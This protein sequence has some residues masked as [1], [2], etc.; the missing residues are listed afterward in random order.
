MN[1]QRLQTLLISL[2]WSFPLGAW[3]GGAA[4]AQRSEQRTA[5]PS[6]QRELPLRAIV[7]LQGLNVPPPQTQGSA[8]LSL[9]PL[10]GTRV[11]TVPVSLG[12]YRGRFLLDTGASTSMV[13]AATVQQLQLQGRPVPQERLDL[14]VAGDDCPDLKANLYQLPQLS[15]QGV[16]VQGLSTLKFN[17]TVIPDALSGVLGMDVLK[18][19]DLQLNPQQQSLQLRPATP[20]P[21]EWRSRAVPLQ[22]K[23]GVM[24]AQVQVN[25]RGP[26][27]FLLDTAADSTFIS[28]DVALQANLDAAGYRPIQIRG[29]CGIEEAQASQLKSVQLQNHW[30]SD[31]DTIV[32]SSSSILS[33]L[34]V[35]GILG[36]NFLDQYQQYW[37]FTQDPAGQFDGSLLLF[38]LPQR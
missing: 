6:S 34:G 19:F 23:L 13:T 20:L 33:V 35:D 37:R 2:A 14:A 4:L 1:Y 27:T 31:L 25:D 5:V 36:Q 38:P 17:S 29:F 10:T 21:P 24:L 3:T 32:L 28:P 9:Q 26:F 12:N 18:F 7:Q 22:E 11:Y 8:V 15:M 16:Q 30:Q